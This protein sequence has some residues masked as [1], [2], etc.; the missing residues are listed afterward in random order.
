M[1]CDYSAVY[2]SDFLCV[3]ACIRGCIDVCLFTM[4]HVLYAVL[5]AIIILTVSS[6]C[7]KKAI[8]IP[9]IFWDGWRSNWWETLVWHNESDSK[10]KTSFPLIWFRKFLLNLFVFVT[11]VFFSTSNLYRTLEWRC[12]FVSY[13]IIYQKW[14]QAFLIDVK[15][16]NL[17]RQLQF[18]NQ[19]R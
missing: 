6:R 13:Y 12:T 18:V 2:V 5:M 3:H 1:Y 7:R 8:T 10:N 15:V 9:A 16:L 11:H 14:T 19:I 17:S 4:I